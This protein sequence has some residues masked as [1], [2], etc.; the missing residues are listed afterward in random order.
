MQWLVHTI[1]TMTGY[2]QAPAA[3]V[4]QTEPDIDRSALRTSFRRLLASIIYSSKY[5]AYIELN[6]EK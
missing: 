1:A 6:D 2:L 3:S 4:H 5:K